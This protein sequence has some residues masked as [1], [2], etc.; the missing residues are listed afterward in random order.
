MYNQLVDAR[1]DRDYKKVETIM[2]DAVSILK[3]AITPEA[4]D[5]QVDEPAA[6][7]ED[8]DF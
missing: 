8:I 6:L 2:R 1:G 3:H 7:P 5:V 4:V